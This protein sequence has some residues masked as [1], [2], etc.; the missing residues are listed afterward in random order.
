MTSISRLTLSVPALLCAL[1]LA[2]SR[3]AIAADAVQGQT[4][5]IYVSAVAKGGTLVKDLTAADFEVKEGGKVQ[6]I[7]VKP[8]TAPLRVAIVDA[9]GGSGAYQAG[10]ANFIQKLVEVAEFSVTSVIVQP[11]KVVDFTSEVP[12]L[13]EAIRSI[14]PSSRSRQQGQLM[15]ALYDAASTIAAPGKRTVILAARVGG[16]APSN[17]RPEN[18]RNLL[19]KNGTLLYV[20]SLNGADRGAGSQ[21]LGSGGGSLEAAQVREEE[22]ADNARSLQLVISDGAE[23]SGG[24]RTEVVSTTTIRAFVDIAEELLAQ[25]E[26]TYTLPAGTK[27]NEKLQVSSK[28][29]DLKINAPTKLATN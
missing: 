8:A 1:T 20:V 26:I 7:T 12:K 10:I 24:R 27:P 5:T 28:R 9:D 17:E 21:R 15:E 4:R 16:E 18:I 14:G 2:P 3:A 11:M 22:L 23:E 29:K 19:K 25:Y 6:E 13:Q